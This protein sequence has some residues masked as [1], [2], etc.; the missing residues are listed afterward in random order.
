MSN[1]V[2]RGR[3][4]LDHGEGDE[5]DPPAHRAGKELGLL[6]THFVLLNLVSGVRQVLGVRCQVSGVRCQVSGVREYL[7]LGRHSQE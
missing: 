1:R 3:P 6:V 2:G 7:R 4:V 5:H